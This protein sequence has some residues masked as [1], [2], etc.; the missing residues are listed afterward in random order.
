[1]G[2]KRATSRIKNGFN[3]G[4]E[5]AEAD[6]LLQDAFYESGDYATIVS[7][8]DPKCFL[9]ARTGGGKSAA[10][11]R[12]EERHPDHVIRINPEDLSL[13]YI[14]ELNVIRYLDSLDV[15]LDLL[16]IALWKH[17]LLVELIRH[18]YKVDSPAAKQNFLRNLRDVFV[19]DPAKRAALDYLDEF[20]EKFWCEAHERVREITQ[21]FAEKI[22]SEAKG[23][24]SV[25]KLGQATVG[26]ATETT[27][28]NETKAE[29]AE[30]FQRIVNETQLARLNTMLKALDEDMLD[31]P[32]HFTYVVIDDLDRDW[33]D[34]RLTNDLI[35]CLFRTVL[36]LKRVKNLKVLVALRTN[37]MEQLNFGERSGSQEE[38]FRSLVLQMKWNRSSLTDMLD[39]RLRVAAERSALGVESVSEL[40]PTK[41]K[42]R[43]D[44]VD[45]ILD[46]TL[47]RPRDAIAFLNEGLSVA[48]GKPKLSWEDIHTAE[49]AY[50]EKRLLALRDEWKLNY[51]DIQR[52][53]D[54]F[55]RIEVPMD[56]EKLL[57]R[58]DDV[59]LLPADRTFRGVR[60]VTELSATMMSS[61]TGTHDW[62]ELY[63]PLISFL[64]R[65][66]FLGCAR[67]EHTAFVYFYDDPGY[68]DRASNLEA[69][70]LFQ[71]HPTFQAA[72]DVTVR[73]NR[74]A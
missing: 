28:S 24:V 44:A 57:R 6:P 14:T 63:Q 69:V 20:G 53:F 60:W 27:F 30:R 38:K 58:L 52:V 7:R 50:S 23:S 10:L 15:N 2:G 1:M 33:V 48:Y 35:R 4:G 54:L 56:R 22:N 3:L 41:N 68:A 43:G 42:T 47:M 55:R 8:S 36:D 40:L 67:S 9:V 26:G 17:V 59:M 73:F 49:R 62:V 5:Q 11:Q 32:Q 39:E 25:P 16:F 70:T 65:I 37:I 72:L 51:P 31:R 12:L 34:N 45:Y 71:V 13:P 18:R 66:G 19:R 64:F 74:P 29:Q 61:G 21:K 46:R